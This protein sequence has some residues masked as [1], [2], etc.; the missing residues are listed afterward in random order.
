MHKLT[1]IEAQRVL[2]VLQEGIDGLNLLSYVP[3]R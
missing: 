1:N 3:T 2:A